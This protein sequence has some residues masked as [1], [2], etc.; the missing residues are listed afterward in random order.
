MVKIDQQVGSMTQRSYNSHDIDYCN[1]KR[2]NAVKCRSIE[3]E[4]DKQD[5]IGEAQDAHETNE[6]EHHERRPQHIC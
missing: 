3:I 5:M 2:A 6:C 4:I 1:E